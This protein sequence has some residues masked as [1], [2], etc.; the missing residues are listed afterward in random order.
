M[1]TLK[2]FGLSFYEFFKDLLK[3]LLLSLVLLRI[4]SQQCFL[5]FGMQ[6]SMVWKSKEELTKLE[7]GFGDDWSIIDRLYPS[8]VIGD[9]VQM[10]SIM[11]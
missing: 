7:T 2:Q 8:L 10:V 5:R 4:K 9:S 3:D 1:E 6:S 11:Q